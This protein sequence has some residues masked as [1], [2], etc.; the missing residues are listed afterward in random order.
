[1]RAATQPTYGP[2]DDLLPSEVRALITKAFSAGHEWWEPQEFIDLDKLLREE[3][4]RLVP[5]VRRRAGE[6]PHRSRDWYACDKAVDAAEYTMRHP[7]STGQI[8]GSIHVAELARRIVELFRATAEPD[9][10]V[11]RL[12][13]CDLSGGSS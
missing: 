12:D 1:M 7:V 3:V 2:P 6:V 8:S 5:L 11:E 13:G 9:A 4:D 10:P